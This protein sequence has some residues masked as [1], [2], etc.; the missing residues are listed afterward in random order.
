[1]A[2]QLL[3]YLPAIYT[4]ALQEAPFLD[5]YLQAFEQVLLGRPE[6]RQPLTEGLEAFLPWL[7]G[8]FEQLPKG[9]EQTIDN[10]G[11]FIDP[12]GAPEAFLPWLAGWVALSLHAD[13]S[14]RQKREF[15][16]NM[17]QLYRMRGT[18]A[19][20][21]KLLQIFTTLTPT[22]T[23]EATR[24]E[25]QLSVHSTIE[26]NTY[27]SGGRPHRFQVIIDFRTLV[28]VNEV[29]PVT[30]GL[31]DGQGNLAVSK[32]EE[33]VRLSI[34]EAMA[35]SVTTRDEHRSIPAGQMVVRYDY[36]P[37]EAGNVSL[38]AESSYGNAT[39]AI[40]VIIPR[41]ADAAQLAIEGETVIPVGEVLPLIIA[42]RD[43]LGNPTTSQDPLIVALT[44]QPPLGACTTRE[45]MDFA[46][47]ITS[48]TIPAGR[49]ST[50]ILYKAEE[51]GNLLLTA[52]ADPLKPAT[53]AITIT[54]RSRDPAVQLA[55]AGGLMAGALSVARQSAIVQALIDLEKPAHTDYELEL[56]YPTMQ[57]GVHST[58]GL[59]TLLTPERQ[60]E[61]QKERAP[62][63]E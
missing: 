36:Q 31:R 46:Q 58:V 43:V 38:M 13:L 49:T 50:V 21:Q 23:E 62:H 37:S 48:V 26:Q 24:P 30:V 11:R 19:S 1:M 18:K 63:G 4:E 55:I 28:C 3:Q 61:L 25:F 2:S 22:I 42:R 10:L 33:R 27:L 12:N 51:E 14:P 17:V 53:Q 59:D 34:W 60:V 56:R 52:K 44:F 20:L 40:T 9:L 41:D 5:A 35:M 39:L 16:A 8:W 32:V 29:L 7:A 54:E 6:A 47:P 45:P 15:I 57:L